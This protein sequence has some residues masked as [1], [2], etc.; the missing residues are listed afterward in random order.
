MENN[1]CPYT[2]TEVIHPNYLIS[3]SP[4]SLQQEDLHSALVSIET[5]HGTYVQ[6]DASM[7]LMPL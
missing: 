7:Q 2:K 5:P 4:K 6:Y 1:E 3:S